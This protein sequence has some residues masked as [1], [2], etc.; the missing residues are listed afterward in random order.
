MIFA[1]G[2]GTRMGALTKT[3]PKPL[4]TVAGRALIDHA[5]MAARAA[6]IGK[7]V[8]NT[9][10][11]ADQIIDHL[12]GQ[13]IVFSHETGKILETGGGLK[14]ALPLLG[15]GPVLLLNSDA[16]WT[17]ENPLTQLCAAWDSTK[18][19]A[20][21]LM[22]PPEKA[23]GHKGTGDFILAADGRISRAKGARAPVYLGAQILNTALVAQ[24]QDDV[25]SLGVIW[26]D[27]IAQGRAYG[28]MHQGG[29]CD[30]GSPEGIL[31]AEGLLHV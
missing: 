9:H 29:W 19:D 13:S 31:L 5:L 24:K 23:T 26:D 3:R 22:A 21:L 10:Y 20:L 28:I 15:H 18:M 25:F 6:G 27:Y 30:V 7:I 14:A 17:G 12:A 4:V 2:F 11:L 1:A 8:V 16:V